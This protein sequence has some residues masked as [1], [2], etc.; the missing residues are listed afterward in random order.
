MGEVLLR[1]LTSR[2][3]AG[4]MAGIST[5]LVCNWVPMISENEFEWCLCAGNVS[6]Y[7]SQLDTWLFS[8]V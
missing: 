2:S 8:T 7:V 5:C 6:N 4:G 1:T 3:A